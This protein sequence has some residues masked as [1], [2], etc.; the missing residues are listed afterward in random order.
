M[1]WATPAD[2]LLELDLID[3]MI[4]EPLGGAHRD[5]EDIAGQIKKV[6]DRDLE[7]LKKVSKTELLEKRYQ[8]FR[9]MGVF[10]TK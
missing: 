3:G 10:S 2:D 6:V 9:K 7:E 1:P 8:K 4:K 5:F